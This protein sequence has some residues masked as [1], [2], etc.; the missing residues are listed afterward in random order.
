MT[1]D[2]D[3]DVRAALGRLPQRHLFVLLARRWLGCTLGEIARKMSVSSEAVRL[4]EKRACDTLARHLVSYDVAEIEHGTLVVPFR[5]RLY[6]VHGA[7]V[8]RDL[9]RATDRAAGRWCEVKVPRRGVGH[10]NRP[11]VVKMT[12]RRVVYHGQVRAAVAPTWWAAT[13]EEIKNP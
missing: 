10:T 6:T 7:F 8:V 9:G 4:L 3:I 1:L 11:R 2:S 13:I 5:W 12:V